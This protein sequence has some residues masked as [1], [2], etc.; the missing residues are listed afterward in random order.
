MQAQA[1]NNIKKY[2]G[3]KYIALNNKNKI[4]S[5]KHE[6]NFKIGFASLFKKKNEPTCI[7]FGLSLHATVYARHFTPYPS[8]THPGQFG[9]PWS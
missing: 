4:I 5:T 8:N 6:L 7:K 1:N 2:I 3:K 9:F